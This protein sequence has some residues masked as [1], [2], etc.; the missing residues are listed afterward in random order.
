[1]V[2]GAL[3]VN[4]W[5]TEEVTHIGQA[6]EKAQDVQDS[7][8]SSEVQILFPIPSMLTFLFPVP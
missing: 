5:L 6:C 7:L 2:L 4:L 1:M 3:S 8:Q